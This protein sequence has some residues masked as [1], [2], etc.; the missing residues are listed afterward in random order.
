MR[1]VSRYVTLLT[2]NDEFPHGRPFSAYALSER[3]AFDAESR[4]GT[5]TPALMLI[6]VPHR[7]KERP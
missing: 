3:D 2:P 4:G 5:P 6:R 1:G 7:K